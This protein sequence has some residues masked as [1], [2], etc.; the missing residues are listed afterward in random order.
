MSRVPHI[1]ARCVALTLALALVL[2]PLRL[3][4]APLVISPTGVPLALEPGKGI[5]LR[6][7]RPAGNIFVAD[8]AIADVQVKSP[9]VVYVIGKA[10][11]TTTLF[12]LDKQDQVLLNSQ[13]EVRTDTGS[14]QRAMQQLLPGTSA[15]VRSVNDSIVLEGSVKSAAEGDDLRKIAA[16]Y[17]TDDKQIVNK[18]KIDA[19]NQVNLRV[20]VAE[21]SRTVEKQ[22]GIDWFNAANT[23]AAAFGLVSGGTAITAATSSASTIAPF[24]PGFNSSSTAPQFFNTQGTGLLSSNTTSNLYGGLNVGSKSI[25]ALVSAL[26]NEGLITILAEPNLTAVSGQKASFL[27][28]GQFPVPVPQASGSGTVITIDYKS[29][30]VS[31]AFV[32]TI[33]GSNRISLHVEPEVSQIDTSNEVSIAG[34]TVPG[35]STRKAE[36]TVELAS[37]QTFAIAGL[38]QN[39]LT[40][41]LN[42][43]PWLG[44]LPV[45]GA[46]FRSEAFQRNESEL[47]ILVTPY[48][49]RPVSSSEQM[50]MPTDGLT[51]PNDA[52]RVFMGQLNGKS[53]TPQQPTSVPPADDTNTAVVLP[54]GRKASAP[55]N[56]V[57]FEID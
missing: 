3:E 12:A 22:F 26:E 52:E 13:I 2:T 43:Y 10:P 48:I 28:G 16:R 42:K 14:L 21:V 5:I 37:G 39:N 34:T 6:L 33:L 54:D 45:L 4:A 24:L 56:Q 38:M 32:A 50:A 23:G 46:L 20:R 36:T 1:L 47:V 29:F 25:N 15:T 51:T 49:V 55:L 31:L 41:Q 8:P 40:Q 9:T 30:G 18:L 35:I 44:D 19:P 27:A 57:G 17:V 53:P 7:E 11:G